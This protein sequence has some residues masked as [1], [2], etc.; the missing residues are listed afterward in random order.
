MLAMLVGGW[1]LVGGGCW[2]LL[3]MFDVVDDDLRWW[4][5]SYSGFDVY[6]Y[7]ATL[8]LAQVSTW[9]ILPRWHFQSKQTKT[10]AAQT[11]ESTPDLVLIGKDAGERGAVEIDSRVVSISAFLHVVTKECEH[12]PDEGIDL[13]MFYTLTLRRMSWLVQKIFN[14]RTPA[15]FTDVGIT[16]HD[17]AFNEVT[18]TYDVTPVS[19]LIKCAH[20]LQSDTIAS[21]IIQAINNRTR[22]TICPPISR[23]RPAPGQGADIEAIARGLYACAFEKTYGNDAVS[24]PIDGG[25]PPWSEAVFRQIVRCTRNDERLFADLCDKTKWIMFRFYIK[26]TMNRSG[27][28]VFKAE[29]SSLKSGSGTWTLTD[30]S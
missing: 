29:P 26:N 24:A 27:R 23:R 16:L 15:A 20:Y 9:F 1:W 10:A 2:W 3:W 8:A 12:K 4:R 5:G 28:N 6:Y 7:F 19:E 22:D 21:W 13:Q 14:P 11:M 30:K 18:C 17:F 25:V